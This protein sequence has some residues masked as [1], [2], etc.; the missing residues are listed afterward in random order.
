MAPSTLISAHQ[1]YALSRDPSVSGVLFAVNVQHVFIKPAWQIG[2]DTTD[3]ACISVSSLLSW[4]LL[5][6][7][8]ISSDVGMWEISACLLTWTAAGS[9]RSLSLEK[10]SSFRFDT[11]CPV[12]FIF[13]TFK[14]LNFI[15]FYISF[16]PRQIRSP[17]LSDGIL[18]VHAAEASTS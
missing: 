18:R 16:F 13:R 3:W 10:T 12:N 17:C 11:S 7:L 4:K 9:L 2:P 6:A 8:G 14:R 15:P 1:G 5:R